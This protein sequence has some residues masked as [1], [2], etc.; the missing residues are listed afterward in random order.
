[1]SIPSESP[2][3]PRSQ[4]PEEQAQH[5]VQLLKRS[6]AMLE[7]IRRSEQASKKSVLVK[8]DRERLKKLEKAL[9]QCLADEPVVMPSAHQEQSRRIELCRWGVAV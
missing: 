5:H 7:L 8:Q 6:L 4:S 1:M 3:P 9:Q 2:P